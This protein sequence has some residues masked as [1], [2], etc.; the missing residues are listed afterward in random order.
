MRLWHWSLSQDE[1]RGEHRSWPDSSYLKT[2]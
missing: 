1:A 2:K